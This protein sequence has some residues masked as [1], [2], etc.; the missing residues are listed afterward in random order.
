MIC[1]CFST[2]ALVPQTFGITVLTTLVEPSSVSCSVMSN[3]LWPMDFSLPGSSILGVF[4][5]KNTKVGCH[6][7]HQEIYLT[8]GLN[9]G[10][11]CFRQTRPS[12]PS[13]KSRG[14]YKSSGN[15]LEGKLWFSRFQIGFGILPSR[16]YNATGP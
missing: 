12:E 9:P 2:L 13:A 5:G 3:F 7:L 11:L 15:L 6:A 4:P 8:Q 1:P 16:L 14:A 10:L